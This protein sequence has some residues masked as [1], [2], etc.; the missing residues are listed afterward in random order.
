ML[1]Q[2][3][4]AW[5]RGL[6]AGDLPITPG[7][8]NMFLRD[9]LRRKLPDFKA[10]DGLWKG[11][12]DRNLFTDDA[13]PGKYIK[14]RRHGF[15]VPTFDD[16]L[17]GLKYLPTGL[18]ARGL[19]QCLVWYLNFRDKFSPRLELN[20]LHTQSLIRAL[21]QPLKAF[22]PQNLDMNALKEWKEKGTFAERRV[23]DEER[24][25]ENTVRDA[26]EIRK[27]QL[28]LIPGDESIKLHLKLHTRHVLMLPFV[29][30]LGMTG[31][32]L[33]MGVEKAEERKAEKLANEK[34]PEEEDAE[35]NDKTTNE[36]GEGEQ[37]DKLRPYRIPKRPRVEENAPSERPSKMSVRKRSQ[38]PTALRLLSASPAPVSSRR[39]SSAAF[40]YPGAAAD[41]S[42]PSYSRRELY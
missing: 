38:V 3:R 40:S 12:P 23:E 29:A 36:T 24:R 6:A 25:Y 33:E 20:V 11:K 9:A 37:Q 22:G 13:R 18:D 14:D 39:P 35:A 27:S 4:Q 21:R 19:T 15:I 2:T 8:M 17:K 34:K 32:A 28:E 7:Q 30:M 26:K 10:T 42:D 1:T 41:L 31:K 5:F 16:L